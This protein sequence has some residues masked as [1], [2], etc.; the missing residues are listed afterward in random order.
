MIT[1][2]HQIP[3]PC[4]IDQILTELRTCKPDAEVLYDFPPHQFP[5]DVA[6][7]RGSYDQPAL[8]HAGRDSH[9]DASVN[10]RGRD[11]NEGPKV[12]ELIAELEKAISGKIYEGWKGGGYRYKGSHELYV[13]NPGEI[14]YAKIVG[15]LDK[16]SRVFLLTAFE[17]WW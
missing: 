8:G 12:S 4:D 2:E 6:S 5:T 16:D 15:V 13:A 11:R 9:N 1:K 10:M 17:D 3:E 7:Y 14:S